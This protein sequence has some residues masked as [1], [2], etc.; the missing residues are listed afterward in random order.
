MAHDPE[1]YSE[2]G[3]LVARA[4]ELPL[5]ELLER[6]EFS[7]MSGLARPAPP[8]RHVN[9]LH[10]V[11]GFLKQELTGDDK[12]EIL[13]VIEEYREG[14][15]P[16]VAPLALLKFHLRKVDNDWIR[17]QV[18]LDPYPRELALRSHL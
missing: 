14:I 1:S 12:R 8:K 7:L 17:S 6:Y 5:D 3:R 15:V 16:L 9:T 10:H 2:M 13:S 18:Y 4:G 11:M